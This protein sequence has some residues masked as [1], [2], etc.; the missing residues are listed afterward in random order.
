MP[1]KFEKKEAQIR[2]TS[3][4]QAVDGVLENHQGISLVFFFYI[5]YIYGWTAL[6][7]PYRLGFTEG[8]EEEDH[9][10]KCMESRRQI[11][12]PKHALST[13]LQL[14]NFNGLDF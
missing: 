7:F 13:L 5:D 10:S 12:L 8:A 4:L 9:V 11:K 3:A 1:R 6:Y 14:L 2:R